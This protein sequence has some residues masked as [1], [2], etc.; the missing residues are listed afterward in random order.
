M[1][2]MPIVADTNVLIAHLRGDTA[3]RAAFDHALGSGESIVASVLTRVEI[4]AGMLPGEEAAVSNLFASIDW[5][6]VTQAVA[7]RAAGFANQYR[8]AFSGIDVVDYVIAA[9]TEHVGAD[10]WT[11]NVRHFPMFPDL[12]PPY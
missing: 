10:L 8:R 5:V 6:D 12:A 11:L 1:G 9:T 4:Y 2:A 7:E 3:A